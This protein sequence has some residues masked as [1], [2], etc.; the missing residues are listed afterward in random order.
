MRRTMTATGALMVYGSRSR[1]R[2]S[3]SGIWL[4]VM[5]CTVAVPTFWLSGHKAI[6]AS[7][8]KN[9]SV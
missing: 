3:A 4:T 9:N 1:V 5:R 8:T 2:P 7:T 6:M